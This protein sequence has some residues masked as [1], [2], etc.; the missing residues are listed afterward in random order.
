MTE[1][2]PCEVCSAPTEHKCSSCQSVHYCSREHQK[3]HWKL[4]KQQCVPARVKE[5]GKY[6][7]YLEAIRSLKAGEIVMKEAPLI[8]GPSQVTPPV[9][10][11]C[12]KLLEEGKTVSCQKCGWPFCSEACTRNEVHTPECYYTQQRGEKVSVSTYGVPHPNYQCIT[13]LRCLYQRDNNPK[14]WSKLQALES[15]DEDRKGT[16]KW[17]NDRKMVAEFIWKFFKLEG[18]FNEDE[19]MKCCGIIQINGHEVP[20]LEPEYVAVFD[21]ISMVEHN[22]RANCNKSFTS[23]GQIILSAGVNISAGSHLS[24]C[25][26]DPLW[27]TEARRHHL[28]DS[29]FFE[30]C[31]ERCSDVT[32]L[33]TMFS[34]VKCKK[35]DCKGY[36]LPDTFI[37]PILHK[38]KSPDPSTRG[39]DK[40]F[41][42][43]GSC[44]DEVTDAIIQ[45]LLQ[46]IGRELSVMPKGEPDA[47]ERFIG[48]C[49]TYLHPSHYYMTDVSLALAQMIGQQDAMGLAG[50]TDD[51]LLLK[52]Q[53][54]RKI[55]DLLEILGPAETR[56]RGSLLFELHAAVAETGRRKSLTEGPMVMLGYITESRKILLESATLLAHEP[57]ELPEGRLGRQARANLL[58]IDELIL[59]LSSALPSPL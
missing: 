8:S 53:L 44:K 38:T 30:C 56:L 4:H 49:S 3:Q 12:Y 34:A 26:T 5:D 13:V 54:C 7:R 41:W 1:Q 22:C 45:Q 31:C 39:L 37:L 59:N 47:C 10:L 35:K 27:G 29:K 42:K 23:D 25:Y 57:P 36:L 48:H 9:C 52:T 24:V 28:S 19:I 14:L 18:T 2:E 32:E 17:D 20:L 58:H 46:D 33:G 21:K 40:K 11:G 15:H 55:T 43:C 16:D 51:R 50:V 6:G